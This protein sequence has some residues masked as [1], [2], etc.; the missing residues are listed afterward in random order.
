MAIGT[1]FY[2]DHSSIDRNEVFPNLHY[3]ST[4]WIHAAQVKLTAPYNK[5]HLS[6]QGVQAQC[7][8]A[9]ALMTNTNA[10]G[11]D[12]SW[13]TITSLVQTGMAIGLHVAPSQLS[14][15]PFEAE[16]RRRLW[17]TTLE[18]AVQAALDS[19]LPPPITFETI[20]SCERPSNLDDS[21][22]G[23]SSKS[24]PNS[25]PAITFTQSSI[26]SA[27]FRSLP[28][29][30][31]IAEALGRF[32]SALPYDAARSM[33]SDLTAILRDT[34]GLLDSSH[35]SP[36]AFQVQLQD[37]L[38][39]RFLLIL[40]AQF[41]HKASDDFKY[42][43]SRT[44]TLECAL[45]LLPSWR[46]KTDNEKHESSNMADSFSTL[47]DFTL[48]RIYGDGLFKNV[49]LAATVTL[50][51]EFLLQLREDSSPAASSLARQE[52]LRA[53]KDSAELTRHR[54]LMGETSVKA[55]VFLACVLA[56]IGASRHRSTLHNKEHSEQI[57][58]DAGQRALHGFYGV[59][60]SRLHRMT[61]M[62][63]LGSDFDF[64][65]RPIV[66]FP[67]IPE[68]NNSRDG[69]L[70]VLKTVP[71]LD[72]LSDT[73]PDGSDAWSISAWENDIIL[74]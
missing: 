31:R 22:F 18:L 73:S 9:L 19:G 2:Q 74:E 67:D 44:V 72:R 48:L 6:L 20:E 66:S 35:P 64:P 15:P 11:G 55:H 39:R 17:V 37:F 30:L 49:F 62:K 58:A 23:E 27:L 46:A 61:A 40:H 53:I 13:L 65:P 45:L 59:M 7:L 24:L 1:C 16:V 5:R 43:F 57:A 54:I 4:Q 50:C 51:A 8:L 34:S 60:K 14:I 36:S 41:A 3:Q 21:Q 69:S 12:L 25:Q 42:H 26:Q 38:Q 32:Q 28:I 71:R 47:D 63:D 56:T 52:M 10:V 70:G 33:G 68:I 29:R